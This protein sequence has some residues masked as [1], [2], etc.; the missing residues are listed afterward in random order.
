MAFGSRYELLMKRHFNVA[1]N[2]KKTA[3]PRFVVAAADVGGV[4]AA[5]DISR[6]A[7]CSDDKETKKKKAAAA[8]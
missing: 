4:A 5:A 7:V 2:R 3:T 1:V 6:N 8:R